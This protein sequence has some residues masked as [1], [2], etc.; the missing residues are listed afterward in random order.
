M[1]RSILPLALTV[2][3]VV[4]G[5]GRTVVGPPLADA[6]AS[7]DARP[8]SEPDDRQNFDAGADRDV[9]EECRTPVPCTDPGRVCCPCW[10]NV[11][12]AAQDGCYRGNQSLG[13]GLNAACRS[14]CDYS[15]PR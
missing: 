7:H 13:G 1:K 4:S 9:L 10:A 14:M 2:F 3:Y 6:S 15:N 5:C 8:D 12:H 11:G